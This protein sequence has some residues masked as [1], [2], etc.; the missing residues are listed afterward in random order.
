MCELTF[1]EFDEMAEG[2]GRSIE[3]ERE[4]DA[5]IV[6]HLL[7]PYCKKDRVPSIDELLGRNQ[8][9]RSMRA[10]AEME[11][12]FGGGADGGRAAREAEIA[13][14]RAAR[15]RGETLRG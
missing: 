5:W 9:D 8:E 7:A 12:M 10:F 13:A 15:E 6:H 14:L 2:Y 4:R 11:A 1:D 3:I